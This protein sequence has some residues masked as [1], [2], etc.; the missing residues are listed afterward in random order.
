ME[1]EVETAAAAVGTLDEKAMD[2][3]RTR[4]DTLT[5]PP[6][7]LGR[8]EELVV[9]LAGITGDVRPR[10]SPA[11]VVVMAGD[12]GAAADGVS[13]FPSEVTP[14]M[15]LN[16]LRGGAAINVFG[17]LAGA[18]VRVIDMGVASDLNAPG[19]EV[20][21]V[22]R[23]TDSFARGPAMSREEASYWHAKA[24]RGRGLRALRVL[25]EDGAQ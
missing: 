24:R 13:A 23:G 2:E 5:K 6:G 1:K 8:L 16:F 14:Q 11:T 3:V 15:V 4:L 9:Q 19:L 22:R 7:S 21:K 18:K 10:V 20:R 12:H 25:L 17:R